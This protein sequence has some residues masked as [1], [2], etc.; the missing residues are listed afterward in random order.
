MKWRSWTAKVSAGWD[1]QWYALKTK[2]LSPP[3]SNV[4]R[5][6]CSSRNFSIMDKSEFLV[7]WN[8]RTFAYILFIIMSRRQSSYRGSGSLF[9]RE[10]TLVL[11]SR[12]PAVAKP[13]SRELPVRPALFP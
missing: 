12:K 6:T 2:S 8:I 7:D 11:N 3:P 5:M 9:F 4:Q 13:T 1:I 10:R